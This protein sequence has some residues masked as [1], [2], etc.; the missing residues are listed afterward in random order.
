LIFWIPDNRRSLGFCELS[1]RDGTKELVFGE[2]FSNPKRR[3]VRIWGRNSGAAKW[4]QRAEFC[5]GE[6]EHVHAVTFV[7]GQ[8]YVLT[9]DFDQAA[10]I[11][12]SDTEFSALLPLK[13]GRQEFRAAWMET[14]GGRVFMATD[15]Q[16]ES[17]HLLEFRI[18]NGVDVTLQ[19]LAGLDGSSIYSGRG[20]KEIF[21][22]TTVECGEPTGNFIR[23]L[24]DIR[25]GP[26]ML[27]SKAF[28]MSIDDQGLVT[29]LYSADKDSWPFRLAQFGTFI[30]P[31]GIMPPDTL[32]VYGVALKGVDGRCLVFRR[33]A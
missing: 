14:I 12:I 26:G 27:S 7:N 18:E 16:L 4:L 2:Y 23:D 17:N 6:I 8:V 10:A 24:L 1:N 25:P 15:T 30:F 19:S 33:K 13:R 28:L 31:S 3:P 9:G 32:Y 22:S 5:A 20:P 11:W 29:E 21:F